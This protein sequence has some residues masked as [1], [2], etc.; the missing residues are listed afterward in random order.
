MVKRINGPEDEAE[1]YRRLGRS[2]RWVFG[3]WMFKM[4]VGLAWVAYVRLIGIG[5]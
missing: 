4:A 1:F 3:L 2:Y 5:N